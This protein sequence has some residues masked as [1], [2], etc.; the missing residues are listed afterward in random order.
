MRLLAAIAALGLAQAALADEGELSG[1]AGINYSR[2][3]YGGPGNTEVFSIPFA[4][5]YESGPWILR[6]TVPYMRI[7][8]T[9]AVVVPGV[10]PVK[11]CDDLLG[12]GV[13]NTGCTTAGGNAGSTRTERTSVSGL[14][15]STA[16][17]TYMMYG[18]DNRSG[19]G[20]TGKIKL[21]TGDET[22]GLGT[23]STDVSAQAD[24]FKTFG[25]TTL[26]G[27]VGY[28][29]FGDSPIARFDDVANASLGVMQRID[30]DRLGLALDA[31][32]AGSPFP[33][34]QRELSAF[35]IHRVDRSWRVHAY[36]LK[37]FAD[38]SPDWG[39]GISTGYVF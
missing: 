28:T 24:L 22:R 36:V 25:A 23:G 27:G 20:L 15:D 32:Q 37:G 38:G 10:G 19:A 29:A 8:G 9:G 7:T 17:A 13:V 39:G 33:L 12:L 34:A 26:F 6:A 16:S 11:K 2:G 31:R 14:G 3:S 18:A 4:A 21:P 30:A 35:W 1:W 5:R